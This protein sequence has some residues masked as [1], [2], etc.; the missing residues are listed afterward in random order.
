MLLEKDKYTLL[1]NFLEVQC[2]KRLYIYISKN[3]GVAHRKLKE[4]VRKHQKVMERFGKLSAPY[5]A[6]STGGRMDR[7]NF[8][9]PQLV[10]IFAKLEFTEGE[11]LKCMKK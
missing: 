5:Q 11:I 6:E 1:I 2:K 3:T 4:T 10:K 7:M 9:Y 8:T